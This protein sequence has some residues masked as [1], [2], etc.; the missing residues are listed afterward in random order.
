MIIVG[1]FQPLGKMYIHPSHHH[2]LSSD[3]V[4]SWEDEL[5]ANA[6][7]D[8]H[9]GVLNQIVKDRELATKVV[10][11]QTSCQQIHI[12]HCCFVAVFLPA[13]TCQFGSM[14]CAIFLNTMFD[15]R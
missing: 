15:V 12:A 1:V 5:A 13:L 3:Q 10:N 14:L 8:E 6:E 9:S 2:Q 7:D 4:D 11:K